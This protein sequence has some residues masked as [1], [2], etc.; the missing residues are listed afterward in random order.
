ML[1]LALAIGL[2]VWRCSGESGVQG[3]GFRD[4]VRAQQKV[5]IV[6]GVGFKGG[7]GVGGGGRFAHP[8]LR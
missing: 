3:L 7:M 6:E 4:E 5:V 1:V 8:T 2:L